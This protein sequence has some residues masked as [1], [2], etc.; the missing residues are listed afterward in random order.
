MGYTGYMKLTKYEHACVSLEFDGQ[1]LIIDPGEFS[2][3]PTTLKNV[4]TI[5]I[6]H[7]HGDHFSRDSVS[8]LRVA[9]PSLKVFTTTEVAAELDDCKVPE[10]LTTYS[11]GLFNLEFFGGQHMT[12]H[13]DYPVAENLGVLVNGQMYYP[14]DSFTVP[15]KAVTTLLVP[16]EA[17]WMKTAE[18]MDFITAIKPEL[19][20]PTHDA[21]LSDLGNSFTDSW[22]ERS[23]TKVHATYQR[24]GVGESVDM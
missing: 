9:N 10:L 16:A 5:V 18:A 22:L 12:I 15:G 14:G 24:L 17:P 19:V 23:A 11:S 13:P 6:T 1:L 4:T 21:V 3:L 20:I 7:I 2:K 8:A